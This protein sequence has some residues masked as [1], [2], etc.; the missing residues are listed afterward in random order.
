MSNGVVVRPESASRQRM[1]VAAHL[2][3]LTSRPLH[4]R[5]AVSFSICLIMSLESLVRIARSSA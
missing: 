4:L 2:P 1:P 5:Y 3:A